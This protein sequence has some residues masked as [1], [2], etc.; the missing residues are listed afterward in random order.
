MPGV[1]LLAYDSDQPLSQWLVENCGTR[2]DHLFGSDIEAEELASAISAHYVP[3]DP[4]HTIVP[5]SGQAI[6]D[7]PLDNWRFLPMCVRLNFLK[8]VCVFGPESTG[9]STLAINLAKY[10]DTVSVPEWP[11]TMISQRNDELREEDFVLFARGQCAAE[12]ALAQQ[13]NRILFTDT[14]PITTYIWADWLYG[15][16][17]ESILQLVET[18]KYDLYLLTCVDVPWVADPQRYLPEEREKF[19]DRCKTE[20]EKRSL[21]YEI[22]S[23][24]WDERFASAVLAVQRVVKNQNG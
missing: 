7:R 12:D 3:V 20:L 21:P 1:V 15:R 8:R 24:S 14:D 17:D 11:R 5:I 22:V 19:F 4:T 23:G 18:R 16:C 10:F 9:K 6:R 2:F 13:A